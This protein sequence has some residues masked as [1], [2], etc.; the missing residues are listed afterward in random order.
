MRNLLL[1]IFILALAS[2]ACNMPGSAGSPVNP[3]IE[4]PTFTATVPS[5]VSDKPTDLPAPATSTPEQAVLQPQV[6]TFDPR[7]IADCDIFVDSDFPNTIGALPDTKK[8]LPETDKKAC[9]YN[10]ANGTLFVSIFTG[11]PGMEAFENVRQFDALTGAT[12]SP[13]P[14]GEA[15]VFKD[16]GDGHIT[17]EAVINGWYV[18]LDARGFDEKNLALLAELLLANLAPYSP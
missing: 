10:F 13:Y 2:M 5:V 9:Q 17:L 12:I 14:I 6:N 7:S 15:A 3:P 18:V 8:A 11:M 4:I 1:A 16:F